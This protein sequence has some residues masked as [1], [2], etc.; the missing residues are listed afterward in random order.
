MPQAEPGFYAWIQMH[1]IFLLRAV[2]SGLTP[3]SPCMPVQSPVASR[4]HNENA[5][6]QARCLSNSVLLSQDILTSILKPPKG[7]LTIVYISR[8]VSAQ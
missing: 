1:D 6:A 2:Q 5:T 8:P 3:M 7:S 4:V